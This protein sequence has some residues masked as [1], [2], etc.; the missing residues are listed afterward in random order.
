M[1]EPIEASPLLV[2][3]TRASEAAI[4]SPEEIE[5]YERERAESARAELLELSGISD[6]LDRDGLNAV[7][8][9]RAKETRGLEL[10]RQWLASRWPM[11]VMLSPP[12]LGKTVSAAWALARHPGRYVEAQE[13]CRMRTSRVPGDREA[14][15]RLRRCELLVVDELGC[16]DVPHSESK[17]T[18]QDVV[19]VRQRKPRRTLLLGN[20][21]REQFDGRYDPRTIDRMRDAAIFRGI[22]GESMRGAR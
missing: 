12:G 18:L 21:S 19:N 10:V 6:A 3:I 4:A 17:A 7:V 20:L 2:A 13:L 1:P 5:A 16:E 22:R 14:Y 8:R 9:D 15:E 11:M